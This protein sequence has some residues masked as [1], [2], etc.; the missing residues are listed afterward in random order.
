ML[1]NNIYNAVLYLTH[2]IITSRI[3]EKVKS[4]DISNNMI[5]NHGIIK[6]S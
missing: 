2:V 5:G 6:M 1:K 3:T 4:H